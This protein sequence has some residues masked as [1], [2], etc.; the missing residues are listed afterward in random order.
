MGTAGWSLR[1]TDM[2]IICRSIGLLFIMTPRTGCTAIGRALREQLDGAWLPSE[3]ILDA[4]GR[5][6]VPRQHCTLG[7]L[8]RHGLLSAEEASSL[9]KV[10]GVRNPFDSLVSLYQKRAGF[11]DEKLN[12]PASWV[13]QQPRAKAEVYYCRTHSFNQW[14]GRHYAPVA[15]LAALRLR[16][17][18]IFDRYTRGVDEVLQFSRLQEDLDSVLRRLG[19]QRTIEV[20]VFNRTAGRESDYRSHYSP[21]SRRIVEMA[22]RDDIRRYGYSF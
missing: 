21:V 12:D 16:K 13:H 19:V 15:L 7:Q 17:A 4:R 2:A 6:V 1:F 22:F 3:I 8:R 20:P 11:P 10:A 9:L 5:T 14:I 18:R